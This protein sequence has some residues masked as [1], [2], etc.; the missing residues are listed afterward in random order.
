MAK[1]TIKHWE[2]EYTGWGQCYTLISGWMN[3]YIRVAPQFIWTPLSKLLDK[4]VF[5]CLCKALTK[6]IHACST[7]IWINEVQY[8]FLPRHSAKGDYLSIA[9]VRIN[10]ARNDAR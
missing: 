3:K 10:S 2:S 6:K 5:W 1:N 9:M 4:G 8:C 7:C